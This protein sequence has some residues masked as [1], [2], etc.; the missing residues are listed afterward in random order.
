MSSS[1]SMAMP[2]VTTMSTVT[3]TTTSLSLSIPLTTINKLRQICK[4]LRSNNFVYDLKLSK[5][6]IDI[7]YDLY[8]NKKTP[9]IGSKLSKRELYWIMVY[10]IITNN[11]D[12]F[13]RY[14]LIFCGVTDEKE[15]EQGITESHRTFP[16]LNLR[17]LQNFPGLP[18]PTIIE[19]TD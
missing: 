9:K 11:R 5:E 3:T 2:T 16:N 12:M 15:I 18:L 13:T 4:Y 6:T 19:S 10:S 1:M 8:I 7:I 14:M 17:N